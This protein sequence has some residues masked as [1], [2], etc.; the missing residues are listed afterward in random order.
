MSQV[1][2]H[3]TP[4]RKTTNC[5]YS[6]KDHLR[7]SRPTRRKKPLFLGPTARPLI[8]SYN[9]VGYDCTPRLRCKTIIVHRKLFWVCSV[10]SKLC[11]RS[12]TS[13]PK[14]YCGGCGRSEI[15]ICEQKLSRSLLF[16]S[17]FRTISSNHIMTSKRSTMYCDLTLAWHVHPTKRPPIGETHTDAIPLKRDTRTKR[18]E[19]EGR[20]KIILTTHHQ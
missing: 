4:T 8:C 16:R 2:Y 18:R 12:L 3:P 6:A 13:R 7:L 17:R 9:H 19:G 5:E 20:S 10:T 15:D 1:F 11:S 14:T